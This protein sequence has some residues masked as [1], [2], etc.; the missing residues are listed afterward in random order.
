MWCE[1]APRLKPKA[2]RKKEKVDEEEK[3]IAQNQNHECVAPKT[4]LII[5]HLHHLS[6][7]GPYVSVCT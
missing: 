4:L 5:F 2:K 1:E 3:Q 6:K 7:S